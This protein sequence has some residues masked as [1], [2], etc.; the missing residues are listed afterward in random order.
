ME[1]LCLLTQA[2]TMADIDFMLAVF[3]G[4]AST[5]ARS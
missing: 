4:A 2:H 1:L 5:L 3:G